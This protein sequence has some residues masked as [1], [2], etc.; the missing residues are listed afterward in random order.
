MSI[1]YCSKC[2]M[3]VETKKKDFNIV[4]AVILAIF[5]GGLGLLIYVAIYMEKAYKCIHCNSV[6]KT[7]NMRNQPVSNY[8]LNGYSNQTQYQKAIVVETQVAAVRGKFCY[9]CGTELDQRETANFCP[10]CGSN[11]E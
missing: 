1:M 3:N 8:Q 6:C 2:N 5:T 10:L 4:L 7:K 11:S 9:N